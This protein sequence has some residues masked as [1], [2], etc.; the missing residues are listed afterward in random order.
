M[1]VAAGMPAGAATARRPISGEPRHLGAAVRKLVDPGTLDAWQVA[2]LL[3]WL[4]A[5]RHH[6]PRRFR[7]VL[8][9]AGDLAIASLEPRLDDRNRYLKLRRIAIANLSG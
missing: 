3:A 6:W 5:F 2:P 4:S 8:G 9:D 1:L 7:Q